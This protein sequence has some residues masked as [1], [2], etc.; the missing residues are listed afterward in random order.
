MVDKIDA[1]LSSAM[2]KVSATCN[3]TCP[4]LVHWTEQH[5]AELNKRR[6]RKRNKP[7]STEEADI[8]GHRPT[9][10]D[11]ECACDFNPVSL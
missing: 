5:E 6:K 1:S 10:R 11:F 2:R 7:A 4:S 8:L 3:C 9:D